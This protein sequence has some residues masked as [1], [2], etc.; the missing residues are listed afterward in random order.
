MKLWMISEGFN[1]LKGY[2]LPLIILTPLKQAGAFF[3]HT[4]LIFFLLQVALTARL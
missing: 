3:R 4:S 2:L 1:L